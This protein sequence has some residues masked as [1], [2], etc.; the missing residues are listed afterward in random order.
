MIRI[1]PGIDLPERELEFSAMRSRGAGGQN[2]NKVET[3]VQLRFDIRAS[4]LPEPCKQ[5]LLARNDRRISGAGVLVIKAQTW[6]TQER[7][8]NEARRRLVELVR[9]ALAVR[10]ARI[11]TRPGRA[12]RER[13]LSAKAIRGSIKRARSRRPNLDD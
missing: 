2:V 3:A 6:R 12:A 1:A 8:R 11:R 10:K 13:R 4:S 9:E 5:R 7:N